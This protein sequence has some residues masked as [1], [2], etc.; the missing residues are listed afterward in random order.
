MVSEMGHIYGNG[1]EYPYRHIVITSVSL[2]TLVAFPVTVPI[3]HTSQAQLSLVM[4][5]CCQGAT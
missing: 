3:S 1:E 2:A 4:V 5:A